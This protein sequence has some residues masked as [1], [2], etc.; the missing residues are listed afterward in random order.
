MKLPGDSDN[1]DKGVSHEMMQR[2][3]QSQRRVVKRV[4]L[5]E[6][7]VEELE[8][9][10]ERVDDIE[11]AEIEP[12]T[13]LGDIA[14]GIGKSIGKNAS[15]LADKAGKGLAKAGKS[16]ATAAGKGI[17]SAADATGKGIKKGVKG[18]ADA[19]GKG[20][21]DA[22]KKTGKGIK[23]VGKGISDF[24]KDKTKLKKSIGK[25]KPK[26]KD[27]KD[28]PDKDQTTSGSDNVKPP[29]PS[30]QP[31]DPLIPDPIAAQSK[32]KDG[33]TIYDK[34]ERVRQFFESQG[35]PVPAKYAKP[36]DSPKVES[37]ENVGAS[38]EDA[39]DK[40]KKD[41]SDE[42]EVDEK[43][44]KAFS[45]ALALPAKSAAVAM[46]DLLEKIPAPSKEASKI[47][48]RNISKLAAAFNLGAAS[49]EVA[50]DEEDN[51]SDES[52]EKRP[53]WQVMLGNLIGKAFKSNNTAE[54]GG[55]GGQLSL[56]PGQAGDPEYG[57]RAPFTETAD[58]IGLGDPKTGE[59]SM[60]PIKKRKSLARKLFNLTPMGMAF[61]AGTKIFQGVKGL[62]GKASG[63]GSGLK[64]IAGKAFSM[65]PM[66][67]GLK[68]G[69]KAFGGIKNI[70]APKDEQTV[71]LTELTD[72]T[73]Q[74]N[75][76]SADSK[77]EKQVALAAG[78]TAGED[79]PPPAPSPQEGSEF[80]Q[81]DISDSPY[82]DVYNTTSQF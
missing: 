35:K 79:T 64:G 6:D 42:F 59:R 72:K 31:L 19:T 28:K 71:N 76:E 41:L 26:S 55:G 16:A 25:D 69:M 81:P 74:E 54:E 22:A 78:V 53:R 17:K 21:K 56:P 37:L 18:A 43:M 38:E 65:T 44:K 57:R 63:L 8:K 67:L 68:L 82:L 27:D 80:A 40:V 30:P 58:G 2:S 23:N 10:E 11:S 24:I 34:N 46:T 50:N 29:T 9:V 51:D 49:A 70:F 4:G 48:N 39:V 15:L 12:G 5:L 73:I 47:L 60:Q 52:G 1:M 61:N 33:N 7:K 32:D 77:T 3:L 75:R 62:A 13:K 45:D 36:E 14:K 66:G 20:I